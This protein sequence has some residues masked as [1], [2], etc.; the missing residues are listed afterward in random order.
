[1][2]KLILMASATILTFCLASE[3]QAEKIC[4]CGKVNPTDCCWE[5]ENGTLTI[6]GSGEMKDYGA[7]ENGVWRYIP[8]SHK[9]YSDV[10]ITGNLTSIGKA[11][12]DGQGNVES[13]T[14]EAP[15][16][17]IG[18]SAFEDTKAGSI[19]LP[20][21]IVDT[22]DYVFRATP[23]LQQ[24]IIPDTINTDNWSLSTFWGIN[25]STFDGTHSDFLFLSCK[26][27]IVDCQ[28]AMAKFISKNDGGI[29]TCNGLGCLNAEK[30]SLRTAT[31]SECTGSN[32]YWSGKGCRNKKNGIKCDENWKRNEDFC[33]RILYT[34]AEA[35]QV[36]R[37]DDKNEI[38]ITF[39][40]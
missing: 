30:V 8:W 31:Q 28:K 24:I 21:T 35:A 18:V 2:N 5:I 20:E 11:A 6:S 32:Y 7:D 10:V 23:N 38:V 13:I 4:N 17:S 9:S 29:G 36:L 16:K 14:I 12:F 33:N 26:G 39:K 37:D 25:D 1:M 27:E 22:G 3:S 40:K 34:P 19:E 15:I